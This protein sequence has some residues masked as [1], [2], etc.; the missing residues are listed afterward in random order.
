MNGLLLNFQEYRYAEFS[1]VYLLG[2]IAGLLLT[3]N[4]LVWVPLLLVFA[5]PKFLFPIPSIR[6]VIN[7]ILH[8]IAE[9][10]IAVQ[11]MDAPYSKNTVGRAGIG[12]SGLSRMVSG[13]QQSSNLGGYPCDAA[14]VESPIPLLKFLSRETDQ[15]ASHGLAWWALD[16]PFLYRHSAEYLAKHPMQRGKD[17]E[18]TRLAARNLP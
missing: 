12:G 6:R 13:C 10:W 15:G 1:S 2:A 9:N 16:Y 18:A 5:I 11:R 7:R 8:L 17:Y 4:V 3:V 14:P